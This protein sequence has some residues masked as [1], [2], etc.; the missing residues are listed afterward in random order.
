MA[1]LTHLYS[2]GQKV[3]C[4]FSDFE[5]RQRFLDGTVTETA[6][7]HLIIDVPEVSDHCWYEEGVNLDCVF[8]SYN[9]EGGNLI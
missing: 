7:D 2:V 5:T 9:F 3:K 4:R 8:P 6:P 1:D